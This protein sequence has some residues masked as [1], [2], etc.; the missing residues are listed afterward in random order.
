MF[1]RSIFTKPAAAALCFF[2]VIEAA[3]AEERL[4]EVEILRPGVRLSVVAEHPD[5]ATPT[6]VD[7][8]KDEGI[9]AVACH[10]HMPPKDYEGPAS[11]EVLVFESDGTRRVFYQKTKQTM[12][13]ELGEDGWVYLSERDRILRVKDSDGDGVGDVEETLVEL[14]S[15]AVYPHNALSGLAW[16]PN[17]ELVFGLGENFAK[18]WNLKARDGSNISGID[19]GGVF[20]IT[21]EGGNLRKIAEGLWNPF[22]VT[23]RADG[24]IFAAE[25]DPGEHPPCKVLH[26]VQ[27]GDYGY[28]RRYGG[29]TPHP[30]VCWN[31]ELR[32]TLPMVHPSGEAPCGVVPLGRGLLMPSWG[33]HRIDFFALEPKGASFT[34]KQVTLARGSRYFRPACIVQDRHREGDGVAVFYLTDWVDG[35]Y[36]VHG[37]GRLWKLE[38]DLE[39]A[40]WVG[41][42]D[43]EPRNE[44]ATLAEQL[45]GGAGD[46]SRENLFE[47][48]REDDPFIASAALSS[49]RRLAPDWNP[50]ELGSWPAADRVQAVQALRLAGTDPSPWIDRLLTDKD[51]GVQFET[52]RWIADEDH[53]EF[54]PAIDEL[55]TRP[56][57]AFE[58]FE[59]A[60]A[61]HTS[62]SGAPEIGMRNP[63]LLLAQLQAETT[64]PAIRAFALRLLPVRSTAPVKDNSTPKA[65]LPKGL[66]VELLQQLLALR[67]PA[68][69]LEVTRVFAVNPAAMS[70]SLIAIAKDKSAD[71]RVRAEAVLGLAS[72]AN[73][74]LPLLIDLAEHAEPTLHEE[75]LRA[76]RGQSISDEQ[77]QRLQAVAKQHPTSA[78]LVAALTDPGPLTNSRPALTDTEAWLKRIDAITTPPDLAAGERI[79]HHPRIALCANCHRSAGRG[80]VVGPDLTHVG[81]RD[82]REWLLGAILDPNKDIAPQFMPRVITL[83]DDS[84]HVGIRLRSY[85][86]E[87]IR[88]ALGRNHTFKRDDVKSIEDLSISFMPAA[89]PLG[90]TDREL[91]DLLAYLESKK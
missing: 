6:G 39:K 62:L 26:I 11:D 73:D 85:V 51:S 22:G 14:I 71:T 67:D 78:T 57:L 80:T 56:D 61:A 72:V 89:L 25:N 2:S 55:L 52:L 34:A 30:F 21:A 87:Q 41:P 43:L 20:R 86:N 31:G 48:S 81:G 50:A 53:A 58:V 64:S 24:E 29:A 37:Y 28:R 66:T 4:P 17:G 77:L 54:L 74:H 10:T 70:E 5:I 15:E 18:V 1:P 23:V 33:D 45:R 27:D 69:S 40:G 60:V 46:F 42:L 32:G 38:I 8:D 3:R 13:L 49:L 83:N 91:R 44:A 79:F 75:A 88:D 84:V 19:R 36:P 9:W 12:D 76:L 35:R 68:L 7:V 16:D 65:H 63:D 90:M 59:A 82:D 47:L